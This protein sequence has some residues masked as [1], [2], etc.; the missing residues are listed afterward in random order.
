MVSCILGARH[1]DHCKAVHLNYIPISF[2]FGTPCLTNP[3]TLGSYLN[4]KLP[5]INRLPLLLSQEELQ[6][7]EDNEK[8]IRNERGKPDSWT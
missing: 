4:A 2:G 6:Y 5:I 8:F 3:W 7:M 1:S